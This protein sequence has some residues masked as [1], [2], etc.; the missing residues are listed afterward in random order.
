MG[1]WDA[2]KAALVCRCA[3]G[4]N[5]SRVSLLFSRPC[6]RGVGV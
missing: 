3:T 6:A 4:P 2:E 1:L 5:G